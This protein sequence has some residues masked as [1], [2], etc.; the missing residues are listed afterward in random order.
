MAS[1]EYCS[2]VAEELEYWS[3]RLHELSNKF[4]KIPSFD[5]YKLQPQIEDLHIMMTEMDDRLCD[6]L[7]SC[8][9]VGGLKEEEKRAAT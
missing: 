2:S 6:L 1:R 8:S 5:K 7:T 9:T 3:D 4:Q